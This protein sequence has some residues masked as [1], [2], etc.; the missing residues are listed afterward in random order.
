MTLPETL[1]DADGPLVSVLI[2]TYDDGRLLEEA[3]QSVASQT[4]TNV[5]VIVVDGS[6]SRR[7]KTLVAP[8]AWAEYHYQEPRG[9]GAARN[10]ALEHADGDYIALL[11]A[12]DRWLPQKLETQLE[13]D[14]EFIYSDQFVTT[15]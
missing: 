10:L 6:D 7:V 5:E 15:A 4:Y 1:P 13:S 12:D 11:D 9:P 3:L 14:A 2:P 8:L